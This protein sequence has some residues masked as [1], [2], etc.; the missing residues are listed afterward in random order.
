MVSRSS[1]AQ[2]IMAPCR[3]RTTKADPAHIWMSLTV[4]S[5]VAK[6][7]RLCVPQTPHG[8][9]QRQF[10]PSSCRKNSAVIESYAF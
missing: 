7:R 10:V 9:I 5:K 3:N 6:K 2:S 4:R 8:P 1:H